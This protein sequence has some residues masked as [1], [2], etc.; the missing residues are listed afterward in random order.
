MS[1]AEQLRAALSKH[2]KAILDCPVDHP[3]APRHV[4]RGLCPRC[5]SGPREACW[6]KVNAATNFVNAARAITVA[7]KADA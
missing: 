7:E 1:P 2:D 5:K 3:K 6:V 4:V